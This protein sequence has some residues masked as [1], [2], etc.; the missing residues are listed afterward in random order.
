MEWRWGLASLMCC[1][2][3]VAFGSVAE[4]VRQGRAVAPAGF[5]PQLRPRAPCM[6]PRMAPSYAAEARRN[7]ECRR[8]VHGALFVL[9]L[10][11][12]RFYSGPPGD[13]TSRIIRA[14]EVFVDICAIFRVAAVYVSR[15]FV[16]VRVRV[17]SD[18]LWVNVVHFEG[19]AGGGRTQRWGR[20]LPRGAPAA[21]GARY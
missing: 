2:A 5:P 19:R 17:G 18:D 6:P 16:S 11:T 4:L 8:W 10:R 20:T 1:V 3:F 13:P 14:V 7:R 9:T 21:R 15:S 12:P